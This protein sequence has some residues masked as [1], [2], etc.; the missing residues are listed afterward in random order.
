MHIVMST[1]QGKVVVINK[2]DNNFD[3]LYFKLTRRNLKAENPRR[4]RYNY[5]DIMQKF[6]HWKT[7]TDGS[8]AYKIVA[9]YNR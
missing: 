9:D 1:Y 6:T 2:E 7:Y 4:G 8:K 3:D 5:M